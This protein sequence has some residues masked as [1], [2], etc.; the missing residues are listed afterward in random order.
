MSELITNDETVLELADLMQKVIETSSPPPQ[1]I[2]RVKQAMRQAGSVSVAKAEAT[3][4]DRGLSIPELLTSCD[5]H[6]ASAIEDPT[7]DELDSSHPVSVFRAENA[8]IMSVVER[9]RAYINCPTGACSAENPPESAVSEICFSSTREALNELM[10]I[11]THYA[12]KENLLFSHLERYGI[13]GP[14]TVM[15]AKDDEIREMLKE[16]EAQIRDPELN[17]G[18]WATIRK[19]LAEPTLSEVEQMMQREEKILFLMTLKTFDDED[20]RLVDESSSNFGWCLI[21]P[22]ES[23]KPREEDASAVSL[24]IAGAK[25]KQDSSPLVEG[26]ITFPTGSLALNE[27]QAIFATMPF[28]TTFID[29]EDR[30]RF[31]SEGDARVFVRPKSVIGRKVQH[32]HPPKSVHLV[33]QILDDFKSGKQDVA[34]FWLEIKERF[35]HIRY[36]AVR[37]TEKT[38]LG[39]LEVSQDVTN[40][41][42]LEGQR[43]LLVY[44]D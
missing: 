20:W 7:L 9:L 36:F 33:E 12:R 3:L 21:E 41:R 23:F 18:K 16:W 17:R 40:I 8:A 35:I 27:L 38:Y 11:D 14:S 30:V 24:P 26:R 4:R 2:A 13:D 25:T 28:D 37:D 32:C 19:E 29:F 1:M 43:K 39:T 5:I 31:F 15:W 10:G 22:N 42:N 44:D 6:L 34:E